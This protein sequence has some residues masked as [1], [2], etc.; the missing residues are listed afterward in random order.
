MVVE[1][2]KDYTAPTGNVIFHKGTLPEV[3]T[4]TARNLVASGH[5]R[6]ELVVDDPDDIVPDEVLPKRA[7]RKKKS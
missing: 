2:I 3:D 6:T 4:Q 5:A 1:I 7:R